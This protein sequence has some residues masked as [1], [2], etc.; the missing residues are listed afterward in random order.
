MRFLLSL[1]RLWILLCLPAALLL[2][3]AAKSADF[4]EWY[5]L[6][7]YAF[8][9]K[10]GNAITGIFPFSIGEILLILFIIGIPVALIWFFIHFFRS[11]GKRKTVFAKGVLNVLCV[12]S[13]LLLLFTLNCGINYNRYTFAETCGLEIRPSSKEKNSPLC[14][15]ISH[16]SSMSSVLWLKRMKRVL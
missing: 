10:V 9:S 6:Y 5:A 1:K 13:V 16:K 14:A 12:A 8:L 7:P 4:A 3:L 15:G 2:L 11:K